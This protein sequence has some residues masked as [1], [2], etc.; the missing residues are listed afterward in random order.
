VRSNLISNNRIFNDNFFD[1]GFYNDSIFNEGAYSG[2][3]KNTTLPDISND[4]PL[5]NDDIEF[6]NPSSNP[7]MYHPSGFNIAPRST[8]GPIDLESYVQIPLSYHDL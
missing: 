1:Y 4:S 5:L 7:D 6:V 8:E 2:Q 3:S